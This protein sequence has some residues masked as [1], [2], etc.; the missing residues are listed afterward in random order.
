ML[1]LDSHKLHLHPHRLAAWLEGREVY[2]LT[3]ELS[4]S[5]RCNQR[6]VFCAFDYRHSGE[7]MPREVVE[8]LTD[9]L[10][11]GGI[12]PLRAVTW[13]GEGE[14]TLN[15]HL[16][17]AARHMASEGVSQGLITNGMSPDLHR[18]LKAFTWVRFSLNALEPDTFA[19]VHGADPM[20]LT[21]ILDHIEAAVKDKG[22][23]TLGL[24][25]LLWEDT[26]SEA[27][28]LATMARDIGLD[29]FAMKPYSRH[30]QSTHVQCFPLSQEQLAQVADECNR[31]ATDTFQVAVRNR[32]FLGAGSP[33]R[34]RHCRAAPFFH[35]IAADG[36]VYPCAQYVG[37][38]DMRLGDLSV[39]SW[40]EF[41]KSSRRRELL[42]HQTEE[43][44][45]AK[46][47]HPCRLD[48]AN[49]YLERLANP[50]PHDGF[51]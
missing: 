40:Y 19:K 8:K 36:S 30:P 41:L 18:H 27:K 48:A 9:E 43:L 1:N 5:R 4:P 21:K 38:S 47:R 51:I 11:E 29:Y 45:V 14:P 10:T 6:C 37:R 22:E 20:Q 12:H 44:C 13:G 31:L 26:A 34:Y 7:L 2:P 23:T 49:E 16:W 39:Q 17:P 25:M 3:V 50:E 33:K 35:V 42:R 15:P 32:S 24:Q 28:A 46:C